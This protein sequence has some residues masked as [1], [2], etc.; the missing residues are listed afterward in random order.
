MEAS[1]AHD[2]ELQIPPEQWGAFFE[3]LNESCRGLRARVEAGA[4]DGPT[5]VI[6]A[7]SPFAGIIDGEDGIVIDLAGGLSY[8]TGLPRRVS[9][10]ATLAGPGQTVIFETS[11]GQRTILYLAG[12]AS[13]SRAIGAA[14]DDTLTGVGGSAGAAG[15]SSAAPGARRGDDADAGGLVSFGGSDDMGGVAEIRGGSM[16]DRDLSGRGA[17]DI[18]NDVYDGPSAALGGDAG[19]HAGSGSETAESGQASLTTIDG[20]SAP[21]QSHLH[22]DVIDGGQGQGLIDRGIDPIEGDKIVPGTD[23]DDGMVEGEVGPQA[24][25]DLTELFGK[26]PKRA[27]KPDEDSRGVG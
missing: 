25:R 8:N 5:Q 7:D 10:A 14:E 17:Y 12:G 24:E 20:S 27:H 19:S 23:P 11:I 15:G 3:E 1:M 18:T 16:G 2:D 26:K 6:A 13:L 21:G 9:S 22:P 4:L